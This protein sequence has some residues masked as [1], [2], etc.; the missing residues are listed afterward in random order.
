MKKLLFSA[1]WAI[2]MAFSPAGRGQTIGLQW[3]QGKPGYDMRLARIDTIVNEYISKGWV[4]GVVTIV[5]KDN[6]IIQYRGYGFGDLE[7]KKPMHR[8]DFMMRNR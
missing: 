6:R 7:N 8:L 3:I 4:N 5:V 2:V 1:L